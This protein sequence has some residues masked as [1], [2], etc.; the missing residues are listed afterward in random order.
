MKKL[1]AIF[2]LTIGWAFNS[3]NSFGSELDIF[4]A[5]G[6]GDILH[7]KTLLKGGQSVNKKTPKFWSHP[8]LFCFN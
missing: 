3:F 1:F 6:K 2:I 4:S 5:A 7:I 8:N